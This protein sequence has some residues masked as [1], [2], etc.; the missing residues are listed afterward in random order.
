[1]F[2]CFRL[3]SCRS[4]IELNLGSQLFNGT[5]LEE[6]MPNS[7]CEIPV[8]GWA[9]RYQAKCCNVATPI[10]IAKVVK[11]VPV[12]A[13]CEIPSANAKCTNAQMRKCTNAN[14][15]CTNAQMPC[16]QR[17]KCTNPKC[18]NAQMPTPSARITM[19]MPSAQMHKCTNAQINANAN[20]ANAKCTN[21][22]ANANTQQKSQMLSAK[23][24][25]AQLYD[26]QVPI[27]VRSNPP[28][29]ANTYLLADEAKPDYF[30]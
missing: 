9:E 28:K 17:H 10:P 11:S 14:A 12:A 21:N 18:T 24:T 27:P 8:D 19:P 7:K 20:N 1:M 26:Y 6:Q 25:N 30:T 23:R 16:A 29:C 15:M 2:L 13:K 3:W 22:N 5:Y 4:R